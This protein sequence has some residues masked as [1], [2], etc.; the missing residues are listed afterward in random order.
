MGLQ[1]IPENLA[2]VSDFVV[3]SAFND[4]GCIIAACVRYIQPERCASLL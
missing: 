3:V 4:D 1:D 2:F